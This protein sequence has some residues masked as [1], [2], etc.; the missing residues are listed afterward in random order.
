MKRKYDAI[1]IGGGVN[2]CGLA[3]DLALRGLKVCLVEKGDISKGTSWASTG[4]IHGGPRYLLTDVHT[5]YK[6]CKDSGYIQKIVPHMIFRIPMLMPV[7]KSSGLKGRITLG[8]ADALFALYD[9]FQPLKGGK[10][11]LRL[12]K[13]EVLEIEPS[14]TPDIIG[15]VCTDEWGI[16]VPRLCIVN[17]LDAA[18]HGADIMTW[19]EVTS[20]LRNGTRVCGVKVHDQ[21]ENLQLELEAAEVI[22][23]GGPWAPKVAAMAGATVKL[24]PAKGV[25]LV[26]D[27]RMSNVGIIVEAIDGRQIF[28]VPHENV[29]FIGTTDDDYYGDLDDVRVSE[30]EIEYLLQA[31]ESVLPHIREARVI[32]SIAGVRPTLYETAKY[33]DDLTRD[34]KVLDHKSDGLS[35]FI[36]LAGGKLAAYRV[37]VEETADLVCRRM[38]IPTLCSTHLKPLPGGES[39]PDV[40]W[41]ASE[42]GLD[43]YA[44]SRLVVR[45][46]ARARQVLEM[47]RENPELGCYVCKCEPIFEAEIRYVIRNEF[48]RRPLDLISRCRLAEGPCQ[49][50]GCIVQAAI[51]FGEEKKLLPEVVAREAVRML[52]D[53]WR[54]RKEVLTGTE[55]A[56]EELTRMVHQAVLNPHLL[57]DVPKEVF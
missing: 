11:H 29:S 17:A 41:L 51:I 50:F 3:R 4:M 57:P 18:E 24:R 6:S 19:T 2:G 48:V 47:I 7:L 13:K 31:M 55:L 45:Q 9:R 28:I 22:N 34:H 30:D 49:G 25:H 35:G 14:I 33:E 32:K 8:G 15:G 21:I 20:I 46:G 16:D 10:Q 42:Y 37:M 44:I 54:W 12:D 43:A 1:V 53:K 40:E 23:C 36:T 27:R 52:Q 26:L 56:Q 5:T 38:N 39:K